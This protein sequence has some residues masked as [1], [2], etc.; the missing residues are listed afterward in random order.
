MINNEQNAGTRAICHEAQAITA[1]S[2][3]DIANPFILDSKTTNFGRIQAPRE[4]FTRTAPIT[5]LQ[6]P[7][8]TWKHGSG[9]NDISHQQCGFIEIDPFGLDR[10]MISNYKLLI[11]AISRPIS[12]VSTLSKE[13]HRNLAPFSYFQVVDHDPPMFVIGF[14]AR[15]SREKDTRRN[16]METGEC[17]ISV[18][19][20]HMIEA[21]NATS[22]DV[23]HSMSEWELAGLKS[24][25]SSSV[26]P[27]RVR[28]AIFSVEGKLLEMKQLD[29]HGHHA[30]EGQRSGALA[31]IEAVR[32]W[33]REDAINETRDDIDLGVLRPLVQLG[34]IS[35]ARVRETFE[36]PRPRLD[37]ES[38]EN[39]GVAEILSEPKEPD[40]RQPQ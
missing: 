21:V 28:D 27:E 38:R 10:K 7:D 6:P 39:N 22:I 40:R 8:P 26:R 14:S 1:L 5:I 15:A 18:V 23:P 29:Y 25:T 12:L 36:L 20:E 17:V 31:L 4:T 37:L 33:V 2:A 9:P 19:T 16:L 32:F 30:R 34:G 35:Y 3:K 11:S 13:G 24:A